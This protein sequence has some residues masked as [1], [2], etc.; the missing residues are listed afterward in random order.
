MSLGR[1][2][3]IEIDEFT[4]EISDYPTWSITVEIIK[5]NQYFGKILSNTSLRISS[6]ITDEFYGDLILK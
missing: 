5:G 6:N 3:Y 2:K 4:Y 1:V